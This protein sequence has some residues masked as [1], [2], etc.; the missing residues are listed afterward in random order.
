[1]TIQAGMLTMYV[2]IEEL[3]IRNFRG[4]CLHGPI[5]E[6]LSAG[7]QISSSCSSELPVL[8][9]AQKGSDIPAVMVQK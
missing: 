8:Q 7:S 1:M 9:I 5:L 4:L 2:K 6:L 3:S